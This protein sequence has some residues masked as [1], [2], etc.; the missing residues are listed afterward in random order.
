MRQDDPST[1]LR[2][3]ASTVRP[4]CEPEAENPLANMTDEEL[5]AELLAGF[6]SLFPEL[7]VVPAQG[8]ALV[9]AARDRRT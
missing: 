3:M 9:A 7:R 8:Q 1:Y 4:A 2:V 5:R 6:S